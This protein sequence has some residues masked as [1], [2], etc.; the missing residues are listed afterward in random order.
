[1][2]SDK[3]ELNCC[4]N[5][6]G[7]I[8]PNTPI[9]Y[10]QYLNIKVR[11]VPMMLTPFPSHFS[12]FAVNLCYINLIADQKRINIRVSVNLIIP[13]SYGQYIPYQFFFQKIELSCSMYP[14]FDNHSWLASRAVPAN[15]TRLHVA[16]TRYFLPIIYLF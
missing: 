4:N 2:T 12:T 16:G 8:S 14:P 3:Q 6:T 15:S 13:F 1:M 7:R 11:K 9:F 10:L 5:L